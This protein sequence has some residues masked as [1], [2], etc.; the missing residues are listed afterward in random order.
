M[1]W[2][3]ECCSACHQ[4]HCEASFKRSA[5]KARGPAE[6]V[7]VLMLYHEHRH[8]HVHGAASTRATTLHAAEP[9]RVDLASSLLAMNSI[10]T[11]KCLCCVHCQGSDIVRDEQQNLEV[12]EGLD[13]GRL[14][15][16]K[17]HGSSV[18]NHTSCM[19]LA[20]R[21]GPCNTRACWGDLLCLVL[22]QSADCTRSPGHLLLFQ[23]DGVI[24]EQL[25]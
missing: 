15:M 6:H 25:T 4:L 1:P 19:P 21:D 14:G 9:C 7:E 11:S 8:G 16:V 22:P 5:L 12:A 3:I 2:R 24:N 20:A 23:A 17:I 10:Q 13:T 18:A